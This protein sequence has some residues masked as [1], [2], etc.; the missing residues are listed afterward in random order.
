ML[1]VLAKDIDCYEAWL[2]EISKTKGDDED[3]SSDIIFIV[4]IIVIIIVLLVVCTA[5]IN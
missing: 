1:G 2:K 4:V 3:S 5:T